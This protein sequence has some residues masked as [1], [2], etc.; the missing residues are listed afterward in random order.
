MAYNKDAQKRYNEKCKKVEIKYNQSELNDY[1]DLKSYCNDNNIAV[2]V[3]I[4]QLVKK[5][6]DS[7]VKY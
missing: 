2:S 7:Y 3:F 4:K 6:L 5:E 1:N